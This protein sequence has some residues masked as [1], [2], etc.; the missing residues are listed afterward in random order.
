MPLFFFE[1]TLK[2]MEQSFIKLN[3]SSTYQYLVSLLA[4]D[5]NLLVKQNLSG[6]CLS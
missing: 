5:I 4:R 6:I 1:K 2:E 3:C